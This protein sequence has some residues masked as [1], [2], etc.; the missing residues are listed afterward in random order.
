VTRSRAFLIQLTASAAALA[1][2]FAVVRWAWYPGPL[3]T[4]EGGRDGLLLVVLV[5]LVLG[6]ALTL[7]LFKPGKRGLWL[8]MTVVVLLQLGA[9]AYG[10]WALHDTRPVLLVHTDDHFAPLTRATLSEWDP[11]SAVLG[12]W[13]RLTLQKVQVALPDDPEAYAAVLRESRSRPGGLFALFDRY[14]SLES[15]WQQALR[16]AV[17]IEPYVARKTEWRQRLDTL[18]ADLGRP[19]ETLAFFPYIGRQT[20][21]FLVF[22]RG[23][24]ALVGLLD[25][26]YD[27][28]LARPEVSRLQRAGLRPPGAGGQPPLPSG[29]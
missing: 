27:P 2:V 28:L 12:K 8:D 16:D 25:I 24:G 29:S 4:L 26:P 15:A 3:F 5:N 1:A 22:D 10:L 19:L 17:R 7:L 21:A 14:Q 23:S 11:G 18:L 9:L 20:R 13:E 6:P